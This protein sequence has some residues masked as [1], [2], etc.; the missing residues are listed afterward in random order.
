MRPCIS[1]REGV[2]GEKEMNRDGGEGEERKEKRKR[3]TSLYM[4]NGVGP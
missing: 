3:G 4:Q 1:E 2:G